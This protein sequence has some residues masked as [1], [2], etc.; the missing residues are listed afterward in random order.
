[1]TRLQELAR[2]GQSIWLD[3]LRRSFTESGE[4]QALI[5][6][7]LRGVASNPSIF[8]KAIAGSNDYDEQLGRL[9]DA[10]KPLEEIYEALVIEDIRR[11]ADLLRPVYNQTGGTDGYV[12]LEASPKLAHDT[13]GTINEVRHL[14]TSVERPNVMVKVPATPEGIPAIEALIGEGINVNVT[15]IFSLDQYESVTQ[16]YIAGLEKLAGAGADIGLVT[17]VASF[18]VSHVDSV[19]DQELEAVGAAGR[20]LR[21]VTAIS[22]AKLAYARFGEIFSSE[23]GEH[24]ARRV[25]GFSAFCGLVPAPKTLTIQIP[26]MWTI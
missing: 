23:R 12:S 1:M 11:D 10:G 26:C 18:F 25:R 15:L 2:L 21:G 4:L 17:S 5:D 8:E 14:F 24:L 7:G 9:A 20:H 3:Y 22:N 13:Y 19:V 6:K 16:A